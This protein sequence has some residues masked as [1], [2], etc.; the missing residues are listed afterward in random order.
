MS[1]FLKELS[2]AVKG[3]LR[4]D[5][6]SRRAY[7]V[8]ASIYEV[9]P[10]AIL[11]PL[12]S[13]EVSVALQI[14]AKHGVSVTARGAATGIAGGCLGKGLILDLSRHLNRILE[15]NINEQYALCE[16]GVIQDA[17]NMALHPFGYRLGPDTSTGDRATLGGMLANNAAGARSLRYGCM[18]DHILEVELALATGERMSSTA[19]PKVLVE[20][21]Q[22]IADKYAEEIRA[23]FPKLPRRVSGYNLEAL[24]NIAKLIAG[25]EGTLGIVTAMKLKIVPNFKHA[26]L[27]LLPYDNMLQ[28]MRDVERLLTFQPLSLEMID[29]K[30]MQL[31][32]LSLLKTIPEALFLV[33]F[34]G[35]TL[36]EATARAAALGGQVVTDSKTIAEI[37]SLRKAGLGLL[38]S[39]RTYSR[40]IAFIEDL[41]V[42]PHALAPFM[43]QFLALL[44]SKGK[45]AG[46][47]GHVGAGCLHIR[48]YIDLR[49]PSELTLM[50]QL[51]V[52]VCDLVV[53]HGGVLSGEHGDGLVR[54]WL[55]ERLFGKELYAAFEEVKQAFDPS[56]RLNPGKIVKGAP[57]EENL[58]L[59][60]TTP[61][62]SWPTFL[63]FQQEGGIEL[64]A[65]L[66]NGNGLCRKADKVMCPSFQVTQDEYDTTRARAQ[67]LRGIIH[68][69]LTTQDWEGLHDVLDLCIECKGCKGE[70]PSQVD[71]AKMKAEFLYQYQEKKGYSLRT[72]IFGY[73]GEFFRLASP[74]AL[75]VNALNRTGLAKWVLRRLG[76]SDK[77]PLPQLAPQR[78]SE[79]W[80][81]HKSF[82]SSK[83]V[84]LFNDT[85]TEFLEPQIGIAAVKVLE[86]LG[87]QV[88]VLPWQCCGRP[89]ISKGLLKPARQHAE[90][91]FESLML[92]VERGYKIVGLE[93]S[94]ILTLVD[95]FVGLL[96]EKAKQLSEACL[97]FD[98]FVAQEKPSFNPC[99][100]ALLLHGHCHQK[101]LVGMQETLQLL[102][103]IPGLSVSEIP[104]G[105][106]GMAGSFGYEE[107][108]YTFSLKIA[109]LSLLPAIRS[110]S[111]DTLLIANGFSC[112]SQISE[113][114]GRRPLH[115]AELLAELARN[116]H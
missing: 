2:Q 78:F 71:M 1:A 38:L 93:P 75:K 13:E 3:E 42:P 14:A 18:G 28:G 56:H 49:D 20:K 46:I 96:G 65:D 53:A 6:I 48:P 84:I 74:F 102:R 59:S 7:S 70:C 4:S 34:E 100:K 44:R 116:S 37:W 103:S 62:K 10:L 57:L 58:R 12:N 39:R 110:S 63:D 97:T 114:T 43:E 22:I 47:Y 55:N 72:K 32:K 91:L 105:C 98:T 79:W 64:A 69:Q 26:A 109:E 11:Q 9:E 90:R 66:C 101:A 115:L 17:L 94:C 106:C 89:L 88:I 23:H 16:P 77:R 112:R 61:I 111:P 33:E 8:D 15:L 95:D 41:A 51:M 87:Y 104:S 85:Y 80:L 113:A 54:S 68:G 40:A 19:P 45:D 82:D 29:A 31:G 92:Y 25:S 60:P 108:H 107:E 27:C 24:S 36:A 99:D 76:I 35:E 81:Q 73:L 21:L 86:K 52:E 83:S 50:H 5:P 30:I 67:A